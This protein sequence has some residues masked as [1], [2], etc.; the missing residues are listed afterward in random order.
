[1]IPRQYHRVVA[2]VDTGIDDACALSWLV[3]SRRV[4]LAACS[5]VSGNTT[6]ALAARNTVAVLD[7]AG[8]GHVPVVVGRPVPLAVPLATT[9]ETHGPTGLGYADVP[10]R[11]GR[12]DDRDFLDV[13]RAAVDAPGPGPEAVTVLLLTGPLTNLAVALERDP[14]LVERF[15]RIVIMGGAFDHPGNTTARAEWNT[16]CDPDAAAAVFAHFAGRPVGDLPIVCGLNVTETI[17]MHPAHLRGYCRSAG[18]HEPRLRPGQVEDYHSRIA[19]FD[20]LVN[21]LQFYF[22]F[23]LEQVGSYVVHLHDLLAACVAGGAVPVTAEPRAVRVGVGTGDRGATD[24]VAG[25]PNARVVTHV[26]PGEVFVSWGRAL[27]SFR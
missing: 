10:E 27:R 19:V 18:V 17:E 2:D 16:W 9:P 4:E 21:A 26:D 22:Q 3:G 25:P 1:M 7:A 20:L 12:I 6:A 14:A 8:A 5:T 13:W 11:P 15:D 24:L 23:H